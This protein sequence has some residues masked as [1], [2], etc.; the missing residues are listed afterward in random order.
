MYNKYSFMATSLLTTRI[1]KD[2]KHQFQNVCEQIG[3]SSSQAIK[4]FTIAVINSNSI[5]F[6]LKT[7]Q[8]N[9]LTQKSISEL[10]NNQGIKVKNSK[11]LFENI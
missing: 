10:E 9:A 4:L 3:L 11:E 8:P 1:D 5:P 6:E 2:I 7:A